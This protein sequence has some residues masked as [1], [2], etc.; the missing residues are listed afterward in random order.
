MAKSFQKVKDTKG[1]DNPTLMSALQNISGPFNNIARS[2]IDVANMMKKQVLNLVKYDVDQ[3]QEAKKT[4]KRWRAT[5]SRR[6]VLIN[7]IERTADYITKNRSQMSASHQKQIENEN[8][9]KTKERDFLS[10]ITPEYRNILSSE[11]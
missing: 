8:L 9:E 7:D 10:D 3:I 11:M 5:V 1:S 4:L 2:N 6:Y